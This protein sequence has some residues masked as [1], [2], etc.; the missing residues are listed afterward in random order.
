MIW[1][2]AK[3]ARARFD[4]EQKFVLELVKERYGRITAWELRER[5]H[6]DFPGEFGTGEAIPNDQIASR[7]A[8][9]PMIRKLGEYT[10]P[11]TG[12][13]RLLS[14]EEFWDAVHS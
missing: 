2:S 5:S 13:D 11:Q 6:E 14:E 1:I 4:D 12:D 3:H 9:M 8:K 7:F 10:P